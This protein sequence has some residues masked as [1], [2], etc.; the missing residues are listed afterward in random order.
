MNSPWEFI[1]KGKPLENKTDIIESI[2]IYPQLF[3]QGH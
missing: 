1:L 3:P 2:D